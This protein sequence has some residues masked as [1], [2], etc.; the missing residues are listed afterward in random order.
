MVLD[1]EY[2]R[3]VGARRDAAR[4]CST[5]ARRS[6]GR[7]RMVDPV[8]RHRRYQ[9]PG[10]AEPLRGQVRDAPATVSR[11]YTAFASTTME[12]LV[13]KHHCWWLIAAL[14]R[15]P[16]SSSAQTRLQSVLAP[17]LAA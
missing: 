4:R 9:D 6:L 13:T 15:L 7:L 5:G 8:L 3:P 2:R 11:A 10:A 14:V 16:V 12:T 17:P 1:D